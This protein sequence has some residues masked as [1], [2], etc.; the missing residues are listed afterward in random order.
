AYSRTHDVSMV[1]ASPLTG[2]THQIRVHLSSHDLPILG[3]FKY[4]A[5]KET[6][7]AKPGYL[8]L[9]AFRLIVPKLSDKQEMID[10]MAPIPSY[11]EEMISRIGMDQPEKISGSFIAE[12]RKHK[13]KNT[14]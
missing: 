11:Y 14:V 9:H 1:L 6:M 5:P 3:D 13:K 7:N 2:R 12:F 4:K 10:V 8:Y